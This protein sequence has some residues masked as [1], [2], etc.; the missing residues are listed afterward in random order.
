MATCRRSCLRATPGRSADHLSGLPSLVRRRSGASRV[1]RV[2]RRRCAVALAGPPEPER[3][4]G[5]RR[6][7]LP[8][9]P[10][11]LRDARRLRRARRRGSRARH[12]H[13]A[14][15][16]PEPHLRQA[17]VVQRAA[18]VLRLVGSRPERLAV[19][20]YRRQRVAVRR[21]PQALLPAPVRP[22]AARPRLVE[23]GR[24]RRVRRHPALLVRP[25]D[26]RLPDRRR[27][28]DRQGPRAARQP[29]RDRR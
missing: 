7:R 3:R 2:A 4:L 8:R 26:R 18:G 25:R 19:D 10:L 1:P 12:R 14:R 9:R 20:L 27:A 15:P 24:P 21:R 29:A 5:L 17:R 23:R 11:R 22:R 28:R 13:L 16:R 6:R